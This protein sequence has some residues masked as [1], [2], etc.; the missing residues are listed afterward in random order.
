MGLLDTALLGRVGSREL[1]A[2]GASNALLGL[3]WSGL[4]FLEYG[5]TARIARRFGAG[6]TRLL[7]LEAVQMGW[8]A[9]LL[10]IPLMLLIHFWPEAL[11]AVV[12]VPEDVLPAASLY[13]SIRALGSIPALWIRVGNGLFRGLQDTR[14]PM[15][16]TVGMNALNAVLDV[17]L[18]FGWEAVGIPAFGIR[19]AAWATVTATWLGAAVFLWRSWR[20]LESPGVVTRETLVL[21]WSLLRDLLGISRDLLLR[22]LGLQAALFMGT[23]MAAALGTIPLAAHQVGWQL[24][25]F[26]ALLLD[27][28]AIAG[29]ALVGRLLGEGRPRV[30]WRVGTTLILWG[31]GLG[32]IFA[33]SFLLL[34]GQIPR[35]FTQDPGV[36]RALDSIFVLIALMQVPNAVLFVLDG[37]LIGASDM[38]FLRNAMVSLGLFGMLA[39]WAGGTLAGT[40]LGVW[41]GI[42]L[43]MWGRLLAMGWR[44]WSR[45]W[46]AADV[47]RLPDGSTPARRGSS[48]GKPAGCTHS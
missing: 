32:V 5:T 29:Q 17:L 40:L 8:L 20:R 35:V 48:P 42:S 33:G 27:S 1:A 14:T 26:L 45:R 22:T 38:R 18:I 24:W 7:A 16:I 28:L 10:G 36:L 15:A 3:L 46:A 37:L 11:L 31:I 43:F 6:E 21:R 13:L 2:L 39:A 25:A 30:A 34:R 44:W 47:G 4:I 9:L 19:G 12:H 23:R 41:L